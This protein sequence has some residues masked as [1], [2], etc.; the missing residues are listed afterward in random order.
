MP[1]KIFFDKRVKDDVQQAIDYLKL[2]SSDAPINFRKD[3]MNSIKALKINP[4]YQIRYSNIHCLPLK[5]FS[6][7]IHFTI[8]EK[9]KAVYIHALINTY[10]NPETSYIH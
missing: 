10:K 7:M 3:L 1:F 8:D 6:F 4:F 9:K 5:K 2:N